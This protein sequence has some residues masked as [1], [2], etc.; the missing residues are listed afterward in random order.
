VRAHL[1]GRNIAL[2]AVFAAFIAAS[3]AVPEITLAAGIPLSLQTF[4]V[5][6][7]GL[8]LGAWRGAAS[9]LLYLVVGAAGAPI[10]ANF[11]SGLSVFAG[12]TGGYLIGF[13]I[14][15]FVVG[16]I[17]QRVRRRGR[18]AFLNLLGAALVSIP[19]IYAVGVP[20]LS[21]RLGIPMLVLPEGCTGV[22]DFSSGC[23][24][25]LTVG[26]LPFLI[27]DIIKVVA[28]AA[29]AAAVHRAFPQILPTKNPRVP[30]E[31][32]KASTTA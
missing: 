20:W 12:P 21:L 26:V 18:F 2:V 7:A 5:V 17:A 24:T 30:L 6:L 23:V 8:V 13:L 11:R 16:L 3:T 31:V 28:A 19:V 4:A 15:A 10:F 32:E 29:V 1:N 9:V 22:G 25:G 27:G 14:A